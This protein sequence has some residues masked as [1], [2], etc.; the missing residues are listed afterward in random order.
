MGGVLWDAPVPLISLALCAMMSPVD[1]FGLG[2]EG[3]G[4]V[5]FSG[6]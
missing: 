1:K 6:A 5:F 4:E 3:V 2:T